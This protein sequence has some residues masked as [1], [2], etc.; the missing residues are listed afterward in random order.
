[1]KAEHLQLSLI[2]DTQSVDSYYDSKHQLDGYCPLVQASGAP[3]F[4]TSVQNFTMTY[5][6]N[7][8]PWVYLY[9]WHHRFEKLVCWIWKILLADGE[10]DTHSRRAACAALLL[11]RVVA[12]EGDLEIDGLG[13]DV[14]DA[15]ATRDAAPGTKYKAANAFVKALI[16]A[17]EVLEKGGHGLVPVARA[18]SS[19]RIRHRRDS[20]RPRDPKSVVPPADSVTCQSVVMRRKSWTR[21]WVLLQ[22]LIR[23][24]GHT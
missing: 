11:P 17:A 10:R 4:A 20:L 7:L 15:A 8:V 5:M 2:R 21:T 13:G 23:V 9:L 19:L 24:K 12:I 14:G 18:Q 1:M 16:S 3:A 22:V 6:V